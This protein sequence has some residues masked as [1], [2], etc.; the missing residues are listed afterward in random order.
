MYFDAHVHADVRSYE[1]FEAMA[2]AG[3]EKAVTCA[4]DVYRMSTSQVY[5]DHYDRL[6]R[7]ETR[8]AAGAGLELYVALGVHPSAI[9]GDVDSLLERLPELLGAERVVA[10][11]E[12]GV[13]LKDKRETKVLEKQLSLASELGMPIIVHTPKRE[14]ER[15][16]MVALE[17]VER[18]GIDPEMVLLDHL[19]KES[20]EIALDSGV[21]LGL[22]I[23][24]PSKL[25]S[26]EA[27]EI[28]AC[29]GA[30]RFILSS[31][32]SSRPSDPLALPRC[33]LKMRSMDVSRREVRRATYENAA[34]LYRL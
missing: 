30:E 5:L 34:R 19:R 18:S 25:S 1:D 20:V 6:L 33:A 27:A 15:A 26:A 13:E 32:I 14:K 10:I 21:Y 29:H 22:S 11:G 2:L 12:A 4:H 23:Q 3:V 8:R 16:V 31:D 7:V 24:P 17:L 28:I 9:P